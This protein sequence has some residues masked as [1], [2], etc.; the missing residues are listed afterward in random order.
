LNLVKAERK[1][2]SCVRTVTG[3]DG[4]LTLQKG[5][6]QKVR[7]IDFEKNEVTAHSPA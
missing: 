1:L 3:A 4:N 7:V 5:T 6:Q 2:A